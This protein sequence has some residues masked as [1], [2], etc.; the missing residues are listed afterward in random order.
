MALQPGGR[1]AAVTRLAAASLWLGAAASTAAAAPQAAGQASRPG[2]AANCEWMSDAARR[3][4]PYCYE[5]APARDQSVRAQ[6]QTIEPSGFK[7]SSFLK[8]LHTDML[9]TPSE[10][11]AGVQGLV[12][13]HLVVANIG[14]VH[15][16]GPPGVM[17]VTQKTSSGKMVRAA[18]T[19]GTSIY[20][21]EFRLPGS[22]RSAQLF[23]NLGKAWLSGDERTGTNM[24][25]FSATWK[26]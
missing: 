19:W 17:L 5:G 10:T 11:G 9:W 8:Y 23:L 4:T 16:F 3:T 14:R 6:S 26:K 21:T 20:L 25:G 12:G 2:A 15:F 24:I 22:L 7:F 18:S 13:V 1:C